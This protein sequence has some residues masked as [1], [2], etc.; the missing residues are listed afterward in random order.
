L[1]FGG[2]SVEHEVSV[3]SARS[4]A[5][6][7]SDAGLDCVPLAVAGDGRW[8]SPELSRALLEG[9]GERAEP[10]AGV[11]DGVRVTIDPAAGRLRACREGAASRAIDVDVVFPLIHGWGGEDGRLQG[12]LELGS[13]PYVGSGVAGSAVAMDKALTHRLLDVEGLPSVRWLELHDGDYRRDPARAC[14]RIV[15]EL[16]HPLFVKPANGGSSVGVSRVDREDALA[17]AL[18]EAFACDP[19]AVVEQGIDAREIEC[20]VLGNERAEASV[21]GEIVPSREFYDYEAKYVDGT[22]ELCIPAS[23]DAEVAAMI[24]AHALSAFRSLGLAGLARVDFLVSRSS[25]RVYLNEVNTLPG[26]T[27]ISMF[28]KL[29]EASGLAYP[30]LV[31][32]LIDLALERWSGER[33]CRTRHAVDR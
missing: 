15:T 25:G 33:A 32:R 8:L 1:L 30:Q 29:W 4:V 22:S 10:A 14:H 2:R 26:F 5:A 18:E 24:R 27:S 19:R 6:A 12:A 28:P 3:A 31:G 17:A 9:D 11:D 23:L 21:L 7:L 13:I 20:A 16:G